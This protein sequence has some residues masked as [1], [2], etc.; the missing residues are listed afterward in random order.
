MINLKRHDH[1]LERIAFP[2]CGSVFEKNSY[3]S[4]SRRLYILRSFSLSLLRSRFMLSP[5]MY[6]CRLSFG[7]AFSFLVFLFSSSHRISKAALNIYLCQT[8]IQQSKQCF[9]N[10]GREWHTS[11]KRENSEAVKGFGRFRPARM[12]K[13]IVKIHAPGISSS[14]W[15]RVLGWRFTNKNSEVIIARKGS[16]KG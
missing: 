16:T 15:Q 10:Q 6:W 12:D 9:C 5:I 4:R 2:R 7:L 8:H 13:R 1:S 3:F 11:W 14:F